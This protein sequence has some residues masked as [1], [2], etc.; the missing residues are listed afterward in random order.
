ML[1]ETHTHR[2]TETQ[3]EKH[4]YERNIHQLPPVCAQTGDQTCNPIMCA[5]WESH[6]PLSGVWDDDPTGADGD[7][8]Q[9]LGGCERRTEPAMQ[10]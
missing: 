7:R 6:L 9:A 2:D 10:S 3:R 8:G 4:G 5:D 1:R